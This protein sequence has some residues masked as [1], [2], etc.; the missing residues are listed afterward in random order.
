MHQIDD[1]GEDKP[2]PHIAVELAPHKMKWNE[3]KL[4]VDVSKYS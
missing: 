2:L 3:I 4:T 1:K